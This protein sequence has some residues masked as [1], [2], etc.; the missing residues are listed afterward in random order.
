MKA[1][2]GPIDC[3]RSLVRN[4]GIKGL[5][6]GFWGTFSFRS[7]MGWYFMSYEYA[8]SVVEKV[9]GMKKREKEI[10]RGW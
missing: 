3:V 6:W 5:Y 7:F 4:N 1:Y 8:K 9:Q 10:A 2:I